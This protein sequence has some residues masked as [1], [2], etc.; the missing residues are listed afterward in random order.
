MRLTSL[1]AGVP[2]PALAALTFGAWAPAHAQSG[3]LSPAA[4]APAAA[5]PA[6]TL[7]VPSMTAPLALGP[8]SVNTGPLGTWYI[9]GALS[10]LGLTQTNPVGGD[11][12][13]IADLG[14]AQGF[15]QKIDGLLRFYVQAGGYAVPALGVSYGQDSA[16]TDTPRT[17]YGLVPQAFV[18]LAPSE[19][20]SLQAGKL[21]SLIGGEYTF[22]F[23]NID[24]A[25]G[26]LWSQE[27]AVSRG[28]QAN[29]IIG[30]VGFSVSVNDG[31]YANRYGWISGSASWTIDAANLLVFAAGANLRPT[32]VNSFATPRAQNN[33]SIYNLIYTYAKGAWTVTPYLQA[34]HVAAD[35]GIGLRHGAASFGG[36]LLVNDAITP[37]I[38]LGGR[39]EYI[40]S[41]GA[42]VPGATNLLY[43]P[44][45]SAVS[46]TITPAYTMGH[47]F[48]RA[49][50]AVVAIGQA[51]R[52]DGFGRSGD[53]TLQL[54]GLIEAG[55][56]F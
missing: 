11:R 2:A 6:V 9:D 38:S 40:A 3:P 46:A 42:R 20:F 28:V 15:V 50:A 7:P 17:L 10:G 55:Y 23:E 35:A 1:L 48:L 44:G 8:A 16:A 4:P 34:T 21:P 25:R 51:G 43:G 32:R 36:A 29:Q 22:T 56:L 12:G 33:S 14:N 30:P 27:P 45:S 24:I 53:A 47:W 5:A 52:G 19:N 39:V 18:K 54:R 49:E 37:Q 26:L 13:A 41:T 31:F